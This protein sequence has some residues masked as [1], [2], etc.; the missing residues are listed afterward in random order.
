MPKF[1]ILI[2]TFDHGDTIRFPLQCL[3]EQTEQDYEV[4]IVGDGVPPES[5]E[6]LRA[7]AAEDKRISFIPFPKHVSRGEP[8]RHQV[9]ADAKGCHICYLTDRDLWMPD[10]L[11]RLGR[12]LETADFTHSLGLHILPSDQF[13]FF[14]VDLANPHDRRRMLTRFN[15]VPLSC[16]AH[17]L[18]M[19]RRLPSGWDT[20]PPGKPT[21]WH[22]FQ[23]FLQEPACRTSSGTFPSAITF[24]SPPRR[25]WTE[26][27]RITELTRWKSRIENP[28]TRTALV[29]EILEAAVKA[30][31]AEREELLYDESMLRNSS[32][33]RIGD[34]VLRA[35]GARM[36]K[37][38]LR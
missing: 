7:H 27:E 35:T 32:A 22:M 10:H 8:N 33:W 38:L 26:Q 36:I 11:E 37:R 25:G 28:E 12:L 19:Y 4:L 13:R 3:R 29:Q 14:P 30:R 21:D 9:L 6:R 20:T 5:E 1:S 15:R 24:P 23:K 31:D 34:F 16:A 17:T 2:P 18:E